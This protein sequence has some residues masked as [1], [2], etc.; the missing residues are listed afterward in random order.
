MYFAWLGHYTTALSIPAVFGFMFWVSV[1]IMV[2]IANSFFMKTCFYTKNFL[3]L[4][5]RK[6]SNPRRRRIRIVLRLQCG[7]GNDVFTSLETLLSGIGLPLGYFGP[8]G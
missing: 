6:T 5:Q 8:E 3:D 7:M 1:Y 2:H 4:L